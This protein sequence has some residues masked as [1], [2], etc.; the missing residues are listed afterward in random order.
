MKINRINS[1]GAGLWFTFACSRCGDEVEKEDAFCKHCGKKLSP[2]PIELEMDRAAELLTADLR[3]LD[4][5]E[6]ELGDLGKI[7]SALADIRLFL[8]ASSCEDI[9]KKRQKLIEEIDA[10]LK[11][12]HRNCDKFW[13]NPELL[14]HMWWEWSGNFR[15]CNEDG[16]VK[17]T[18]GEWLLAKATEKETEE[19]T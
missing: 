17:M 15:N 10:A 4:S 2:L 13:R 11:A 8:D 12:P 1:Q 19:K 16:T 6:M 9:E 3:K 7:R 18:F 5:K 14:H